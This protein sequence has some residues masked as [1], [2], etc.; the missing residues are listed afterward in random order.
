MSRSAKIYGNNMRYLSKEATEIL[1]ILLNKV[2]KNNN[3]AEV[4]NSK[5]FIQIEVLFASNR[6]KIVSVTWESGVEM[7]FTID[8]RYRA[9][10]CAIHDARE[11][12]M[13][14]MNNDD[15]EV[16]IERAEQNL[17]AIGQLI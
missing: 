10:L 5:M 3:H 1:L 8:V 7:F 12:D 11:A 6:I 4:H 13:I 16:E 17:Q 9:L 14:A 2:A 15:M